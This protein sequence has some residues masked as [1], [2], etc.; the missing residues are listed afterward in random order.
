M[1][2]PFS[3]NNLTPSKKPYSAPICNA[4]CSVFIVLLSI[5]TPLF[6]NFTI[7][8]ILFIFIH[9]IKGVAPFSLGKFK[10]ALLSYNKSNILLC[11][12]I[13]A[14]MIREDLGNGIVYPYII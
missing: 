8:S 9:T 13:N 6:N 14:C 2:A 10:S 1:S 11:P 7:K 12:I 4:F 3:N 5:L